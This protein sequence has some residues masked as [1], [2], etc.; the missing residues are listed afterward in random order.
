MYKSNYRSYE[1]YNHP[2]DVNAEDVRAV[3]TDGY[4]GNKM[5]KVIVKNPEIA[6][7]ILSISENMIDNNGNLVNVGKPFVFVMVKGEHCGY[8]RMA[9]PGF[10]ALAQATAAHPKIGLAVIQS[11]KERDL[12]SKISKL[13]NI[14]GVPTYLLFYNGKKIAEYSGD[15]TQDDMVQWLGKYIQ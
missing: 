14:R 10:Q 11:D 2:Y 15:R 9:F 5:R 1:T 6:E 8:C 12:Y 7:S 13:F 4:G 3:K